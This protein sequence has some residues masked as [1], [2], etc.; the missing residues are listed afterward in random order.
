MALLVHKSGL[1]KGSDVVESWELGEV[2][3]LYVVCAVYD[4]HACEGQELQTRW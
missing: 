2:D 3:E 4:G 1:F